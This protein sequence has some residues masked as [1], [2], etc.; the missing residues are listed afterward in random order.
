MKDQLSQYLDT[1]EEQEDVRKVSTKSQR[2]A[3][4][5]GTSKRSIGQAGVSVHFLYG[6]AQS[7][8]KAQ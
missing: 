1:T 6:A 3:V 8:E 2:G 5:P 4:P 7:A